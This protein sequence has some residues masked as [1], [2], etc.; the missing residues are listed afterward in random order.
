MCKKIAEGIDALVLDVKAGRGAFMKSEENARLLAS[1]LVAIGK[2]FG[3]ETQ[4][5]VTRMDAPIGRAVG[6][7][8]EVIE[9]LEALKGNGPADLME[10]ALELSERMLVSAGVCRTRDEAARACRTAVSSG[11]ALEKF[12]SIVTRQG[13]D[14][15]VVDDY[16]LLPTA[17][18]EQM[19]GAAT[20]GFVETLDAEL[21]G[22]A[23]VIL[24]AGRDTM[25]DEVDPAAGV[26]VEA[27]VGS[28]VKEGAPI[29][30]VRYRDGSR[31]HKAQPMLASAIK[32]GPAALP[33]RKMVIHEIG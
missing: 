3:V 20:A 14:A 33:I 26:L 10:N 18:L 9:C 30:R 28:P 24:G 17:P 5:V 23:A 16:D 27:P 13:G 31:L 22:R 21:I 29:L 32:I 6:N 15:R 12:R 8:L 19:I 11:Q 2:A 25:D 1:S 7:A 4:A